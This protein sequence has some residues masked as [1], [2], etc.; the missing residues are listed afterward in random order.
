[1]THP[2]DIG[3]VV[4]YSNSASEERYEA[5]RYCNIPYITQP[6]ERGGSARSYGI[7]HPA[8]QDIAEVCSYHIPHL[9]KIG[10][11]GLYG[12]A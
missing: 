11:A 9:V 3:S 10:T 4:S 2:V 7:S 12:I 8:E 6:M 5:L 1:M